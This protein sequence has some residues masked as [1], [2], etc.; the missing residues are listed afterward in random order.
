MFKTV[1]TAAG[2][3]ALCLLV[4]TAGMLISIRYF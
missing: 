2:L 4:F 1:L 3:V